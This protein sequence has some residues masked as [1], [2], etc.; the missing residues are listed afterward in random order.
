MEHFEGI[1]HVVNEKRATVS[2]T[3]LERARQILSQPKYKKLTP[4]GVYTMQR[5]SGYTIVFRQQQKIEDI[6]SNS[7]GKRPINDPVVQ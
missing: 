7:R 6:A 2:K 4:R 5:R 1:M 3:D